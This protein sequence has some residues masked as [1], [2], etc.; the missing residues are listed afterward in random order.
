MEIL[1]ARAD[2]GRIARTLERRAYAGGGALDLIRSCMRVV[3]IVSPT[4]WTSQ[5]DLA[6]LSTEQ[7]EVLRFLLGVAEGDTVLPDDELQIGH[8]VRRR[9]ERRMAARRVPYPASSPRD[10]IYAGQCARTGS[11][12]QRRQ[13][14]LIE[15]PTMK[16]KKKPI[17]KTTEKPRR[18]QRGKRKPYR[19]L[20]NYL[21]VGIVPPANFL[22]SI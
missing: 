22:N 16:K 2:A 7:L 11:G 15:E 14:R 5:H 6:R 8:A 12:K 9:S 20:L 10:L 4:A 21:K 19:S 18:V 13:R 17:R 1:A 3:S